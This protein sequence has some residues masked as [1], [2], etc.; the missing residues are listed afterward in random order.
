[1]LSEYILYCLGVEICIFGYMIDDI[2][3]IGKQ[4]SLVLVR[5]HSWNARIVELDLVVVDFDE[6]DE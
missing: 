2:R 4:V 5:E 6:V 3:Q 1:M